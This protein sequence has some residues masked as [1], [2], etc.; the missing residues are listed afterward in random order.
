[1]LKLYNSYDTLIHSKYIYL[2]CNI[3]KNSL[4]SYIIKK[5]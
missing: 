5:L 3:L 4:I 2:L 1:M